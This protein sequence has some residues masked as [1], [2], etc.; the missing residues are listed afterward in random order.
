[1]ILFD[2]HYREKEIDIFFAV[3]PTSVT[4]SAKIEYHQL[5]PSGERYVPP[6]QQNGTESAESDDGEAN[7]NSVKQTAD[8]NLVE[9]LYLENAMIGIQ[10]KNRLN[11]VDEMSTFV[12]MTIQD[13]AA[14]ADDGVELEDKCIELFI[15]GGETKNI[16]TETGVVVPLETF[17]PSEMRLRLKQTSLSGYMAK[18]TV[19]SI[20]TTVVI[21]LSFFTMLG[22]IKQVTE[23]HAL[24]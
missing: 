18:V 14:S 3:N 24:A 10:I 4:T 15:S 12:N 5:L 16:T 21:C 23:N 22:V 1:M 2:G 6:V 13:C 7:I 9:S 8:V 19:F 20:L 17:F 11:I